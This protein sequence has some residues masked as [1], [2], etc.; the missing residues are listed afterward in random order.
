M[1]TSAVVNSTI[2]QG[3]KSNTTGSDGGNLSYSQVNGMRYT[4][5]MEGDHTWWYRPYT[6]QATTNDPAA[7]TT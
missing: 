1:A 4:F 3:H 7:I 6:I 5:R 2:G